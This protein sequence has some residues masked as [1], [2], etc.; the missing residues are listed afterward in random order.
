MKKQNQNIKIKKGPINFK[1]FSFMRDV[2]SVKKENNLIDK[3]SQVDTK[4]MQIRF[5]V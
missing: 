5:Q 2:V 3:Y 4:R 1:S